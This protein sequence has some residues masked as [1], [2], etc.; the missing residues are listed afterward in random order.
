MVSG[1]AVPVS[2]QKPIRSILTK[3]LVLTRMSTLQ[4]VTTCWSIP[5][6]LLAG[7][8]TQRNLELLLAIDG[9]G[10]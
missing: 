9:G 10:Q 1:L 3:A 8:P 4:K 7:R 5:K 2:G 6:Y